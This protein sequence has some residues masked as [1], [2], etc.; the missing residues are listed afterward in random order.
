MIEFL[1]MCI[2]H[3]ALLL[4]SQNRIQT[5]QRETDK[6]VVVKTNELQPDWFT[7]D[8]HEQEIQ[9]YFLASANT[10][11]SCFSVSF[12]DKFLKRHLSR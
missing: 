10:S 7:K 12:Q 4:N 5:K 9:V 8:A 6:E 3:G 2:N 1:S 11:K